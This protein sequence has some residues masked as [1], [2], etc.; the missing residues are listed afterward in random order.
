DIDADVAFVA[1]RLAG[2][3]LEM[4]EER[5]LAEI[6]N[7]AAPAVAAGHERVAAGGVH[8]HRGPDARGSALAA[9]RDGDAVGI[10]LRRLDRR[11]LITRD[12]APPGVPQEVGFELGRR[13]LQGVGWP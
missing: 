13:H 3:A 10:E 7:A 9:R 12:A 8:E 6:R 2:G 1:A 4:R 11:R 5:D